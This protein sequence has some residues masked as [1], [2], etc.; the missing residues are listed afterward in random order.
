VRLLLF[1]VDG[2]LTDGALSYTENDSETKVFY[3]RDG[4][5][6]RMLHDNGIRT[7]VVTGRASEAL[8]RRCREL[9]IKSVYDG[10]DDKA[11]IL[12]KIVSDTGCT[13][14]ETAF[15]GDDLVDLPLLQKVAVSIA[16]ADAHELVR[17]NVHL[18]TVNPGG[19]G[20]VREICEWLLKAKG[21]WEKQLRRWI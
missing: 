16:V 1:D 11:A 20:A 12:G 15:V 8:L 6:I 13:A 3:A 19:R 5:G 4:L 10:I 9:N 18:V 2:V 14:E 7:G 17:Q 21:L